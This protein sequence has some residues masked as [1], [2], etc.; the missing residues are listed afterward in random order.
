MYRYH[1]GIT[2]VSQ[3]T[4]RIRLK[5]AVCCISSFRVFRFGVAKDLKYW[6]AEFKHTGNFEENVTPPYE[7][8]FIS[9]DR[10][11]MHNFKSLGCCGA[12]MN[13]AF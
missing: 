3:A 10:V 7:V 12:Q 1:T 5:C 13:I 9:R 11:T 8:N 4:I 2:L 6:H